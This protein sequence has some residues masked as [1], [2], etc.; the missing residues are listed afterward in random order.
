MQRKFGKYAHTDSYSFTLR[1]SGFQKPSSASL[2]SLLYPPDQWTEIPCGLHAVAVLVRDG[3]LRTGQVCHNFSAAAF[4]GKIWAKMGQIAST[5]W[6]NSTAPCFCNFNGGTLAIGNT[7]VVP[8]T[9]KTT[10]A[11]WLA[12]NSKNL[13]LAM[14]CQIGGCPKSCNSCAAA[15]AVEI[16]SKTSQMTSTAWRNQMTST[17]WKNTYGTL[18][19]QLQQ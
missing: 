19:L 17:A 8:K 15:F 4:H 11:W 14:P 12:S 10:T 2:S 18:L 16:W 1:R 13:Q 9:S 3:W 7:C 5:A 6:K